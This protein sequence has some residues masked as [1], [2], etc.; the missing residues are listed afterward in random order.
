MPRAK[1]HESSGDIKLGCFLY[2]MNYGCKAFAEAVNDLADEKAKNH[3]QD[4]PANQAKHD[5]TDH[6]YQHDAPTLKHRDLHTSTGRRD[7][8]PALFACV[9]TLINKGN[10]SD[11]TL[12][13][14]RREC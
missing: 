13:R 14:E 6:D 8:P 1:S 10:K 4:E 12:A 9:G 7:R 5:P 2:T 11:A 3:A